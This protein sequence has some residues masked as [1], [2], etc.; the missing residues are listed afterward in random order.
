M[1][2][3]RQFQA[4]MCVCQHLLYGRSQRLRN[5]AP[6]CQRQPARVTMLHIRKSNATPKSLL[7]RKLKSYP[8]ALRHGVGLHSN[9]IM[10]F[11]TPS[12]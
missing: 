4:Y 5:G 6:P 8:Q 11:I 9:S 2:G 10:A 1:D 3:T 7:F 12:R